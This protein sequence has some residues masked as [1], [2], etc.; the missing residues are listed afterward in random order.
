[1]TLDQ[2]KGALLGMAI[3]DALGTTLEFSKPTDDDVL[4]T[5]IIGGGPFALP[6]GTFTDDTSMA[7]AMATSMVN[8][9][10]FDPIDIQ[11]EFWAWYLEG[12]HSPEGSCFDI[13]NATSNALNE[14]SCNFLKPYAGSVEADT[15]GNGGIMRLAPAVILNHRDRDNALT[16][17]VR[18]SLLTHASDECVMYAQAMGK[19]LWQGNFE[20]VGDLPVP[21]KFG[22]NGNPYSGGYVAETFSAASHAVMTTDS[23]EGAVVT[24]VNYR[25]DADTTGAVA[26][27]IAGR[28]FGLSGIPQ[29]WL[30]AL[31]WRDK[32]EELATQ[33]WEI[34]PS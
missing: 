21:T 4:H 9:R 33:L 32:I 26:G 5:E 2:A 30:D 10:K 27:Q 16:D 19:V 8:K 13:G 7:I 23:F 3:G 1:M 6:A 31:L 17:A 29:R 12:K 20:G 28:F 15:S 24:A 14:W 34:A 25:Y 18:S 22:D 11:E